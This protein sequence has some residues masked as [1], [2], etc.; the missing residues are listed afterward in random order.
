[1][2]YVELPDH[3]PAAGGRLHGTIL[4]DDQELRVTVSLLKD[5]LAELTR[6]VPNGF[7]HAAPP[8]GPIPTPAAPAQHR[9]APVP[10]AAP[11]AGARAATT[12]QQPV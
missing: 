6:D 8:A 5:A 4:F 11:S 2:G 10:S 1:M 12:A 9:Q 7:I 3:V